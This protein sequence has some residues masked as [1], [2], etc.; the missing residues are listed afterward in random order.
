MCSLGNTGNENDDIQ[1]HSVFYQI[2]PD[3]NKAPREWGDNRG[4]ISKPG[5]PWGEKKEGEIRKAQTV[6][7]AAQIKERE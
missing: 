4:G 1:F 6:F 3:V 7:P 5:N 2:Y